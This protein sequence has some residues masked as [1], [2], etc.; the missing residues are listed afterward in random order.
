MWHDPCLTACA[1]SCSNALKILTECAYSCSNAWPDRSACSQQRL[2]AGAISGQGQ[3]L[4]RWVG[5]ADGLGTATAGGGPRAPRGLGT[6]ARVSCPAPLRI[7][8]V[9]HAWGQRRARRTRV[10]GGVANTECFRLIL[11][12]PFCY[13][14]IVVQVAIDIHS[15]L[16][17]LSS[18]AW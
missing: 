8:S 15:E 6:Y 14:R 4:S 18:S 12:Y 3:R 1:C 9:G 2:L 16:Q 5:A 7:G 13:N 10:S 17:V 11:Y